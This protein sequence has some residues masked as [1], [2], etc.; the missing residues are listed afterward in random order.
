MSIKKSVFLSDNTAQWVTTTTGDIQAG[1]N[2]RWS[3]SINATFDQFRYLIANS[4][5]ELNAYEWQIILNVYAGCY[6]PAHA[7]PARIASDIM[8]DMGEISIDT[9]EKVL[10]EKAAL[11]RKVHGMNQLEQ[12]SILYFNQIFWLNKWECEFDEIVAQI[13][14]KMNDTDGKV[15]S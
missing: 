9:V 3:E 14:K 13:K 4:L 10:P 5:P 8:D 2:P 15:L 11:I 12:L 7:L 1:E 6:M